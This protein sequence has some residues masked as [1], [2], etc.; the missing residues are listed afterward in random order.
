MANPRWWHDE[1][2]DTWSRVKAA[3][4][5]VLADEDAV[6]YG[7][8]A[9]QHYGIAYREWDDRLEAKMRA[10]WE[11]LQTGRS[12]DQVKAAVRRGW[13]RATN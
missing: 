7:A 6:R 3:L 4:E 13:D 8:G 9:R 5:H 2:D 11:A 10:E 1:H 12:W